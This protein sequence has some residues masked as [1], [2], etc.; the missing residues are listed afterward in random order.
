MSEL[1]VSEGFEVIKPILILV[2]ELLGYAIFVF[3]FYRFLGKRDIFKLNLKPYDN[4]TGR[5]LRVIFY[6]IQ[7]VLLLPIIVSFWFAVLVVFLALLGKNQTPESILLVA[8]AVVSTVRC[9]S[10]YSEDLSRD[11]AKLLPFAILGIYLVDRTFFELSVSLGLLKEMPEYWTLIFYYCVFV[12]AL[13]L[14]LRIVYCIISS[15]W[16]REHPEWQKWEMAKVEMAQKREPK[17][18]PAALGRTSGSSELYPHIT[19]NPIETKKV[20]SSFQ[21]EMQ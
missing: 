12:I 7:H 14:V 5:F 13:E 6:I 15:L 3:T 10:Y 11:L 8:I 2:L 20:V 17:Q 4:N 16:S 18:A 19:K 21:K 9:A 1:S